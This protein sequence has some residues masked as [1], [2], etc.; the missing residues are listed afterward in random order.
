[1]T[2]KHA[3]AL[4]AASTAGLMPASSFWF[5]REGAAYNRA[6]ETVIISSIS[7]AKSSS[8][9]VSSELRGE[10]DLDRRYGLIRH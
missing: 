3:D 7:L 6:E 2:D 10:L 4:P 5:F 9:V 8:Q 1:M